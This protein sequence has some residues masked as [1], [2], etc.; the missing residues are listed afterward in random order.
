[1]YRVV[2]YPEAAA[3]LDALPVSLLADYARVL[4]AVAL[5]PW[6]GAPLN[7]RNPEGAVRRWSFGPVETAQVLYLVLER[8]RE[9][10]VLQVLWLD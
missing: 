6:N 2:V 1:M 5:A 3:Q 10:H 7:E 4:D 9:V 8:E